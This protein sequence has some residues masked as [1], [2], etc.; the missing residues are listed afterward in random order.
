VGVQLTGVVSPAVAAPAPFAPA[1]STVVLHAAPTEVVSSTDRRLRAELTATHPVGYDNATDSIAV[2]L[3][4]GASGRAEKHRWTFTVPA[5]AWDIDSSGAGRI[6]PPVS[7][8]APFGKVGLT[9]HAIGD[10]S[11]E[12]CNGSIRT[13][14]QKVSVKGTFFFDSRSKGAHKWGIVGSKS[15]RFAFSAPST[16]VT[17]DDLPATPCVNPGHARCSSEVSW[18][19][20]NTKVNLAG[21]SISNKR[22][23]FIATRTKPLSSPVGATRTDELRAATKRLAIRRAGD[24]A[25]SLAVAAL[26]R[27]TGRASLEA[28]ASTEFNLPCSKDG[29]DYTQT[30]TTWHGDYTNGDSVLTAHAQV[31]GSIR[32]ASVEGPGN[33]SFTVAKYA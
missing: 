13:Q 9:V 12:S 2:T 18:N 29:T 4:K 31:F 27:A 26:K 24:D 15:K 3:L 30:Y 28:P 25:A 10:P 1:V 23:S 11:T 22:A 32:L 14:T 7:A 20:A 16:I 17:T 33:A 6:K 19:A 8:L 21:T 5:S